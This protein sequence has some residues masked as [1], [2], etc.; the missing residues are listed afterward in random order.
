[1]IVLMAKA[2]LPMV[3]FE[4]RQSEVTTRGLKYFRRMRPVFLYVSDV[5]RIVVRGSVKNQCTFKKKTVRQTDAH[6]RF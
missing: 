5:F 4:I 2:N 1:M 6:V 3:G